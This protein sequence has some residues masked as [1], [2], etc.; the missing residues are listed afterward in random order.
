MG[1]QWLLTASVVALVG[2]GCVT[3]G[4]PAPEHSHDTIGRTA[5]NGARVAG[6][7]TFGDRAR[8]LTIESPSVGTVQVRLLLP[9]TFH[10]EPEATFP[11]LYL[12][13]G[14]GGG[15]GD[16]TKETGVEAYTAG[17]RLLVAMPAALSTDLGTF[18]PEGGPDGLGGPP[19]WERFH[20]LE[21][22]RLL[23]RN[24]QAGDERAIGGLSLGGYGAV[25]YVSRHPRSFDAA[26]SFSGALDLRASASVPASRQIVDDVTALAKSMGW[27]EANPIDL[28]SELEGTVLYISTGNGEPGSLDAPDAAY[29]D[30]EAWIGHGNDN[31]IVALAEAGVEAAANA[32]GPGTHSWPYWDRELE[33]ALPLLLEALG[34]AP[35]D[36]G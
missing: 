3:V 9:E 30:L 12:L 22:P 2:A 8:D 28:V 14:G 11:T 36:A 29:D 25:M 13:H 20:L 19:N 35:A 7:R 6:I 33:A 4:E 17:K 16:W 1:G 32:Y 24:W 31:Y 26:A 5:D 15:F 10:D 34:V 23:E 21:L 27:D 18:L